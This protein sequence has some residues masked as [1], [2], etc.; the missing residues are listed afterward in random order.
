MTMSP[1]AGELSAHLTGVLHNNPLFDGIELPQVQNDNLET[2]EMK[3][4]SELSSDVINVTRRPS[5]PPRIRTS[6]IIKRK[7]TELFRHVSNVSI[8]S[9]LYMQCVLILSTRTVYAK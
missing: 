6:C 8:F 7:N 1:T 3:F 9:V 4:G 5:T 2:L